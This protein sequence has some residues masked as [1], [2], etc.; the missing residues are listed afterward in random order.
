MKS[1]ALPF[2]IMP[3]TIII[4]VGSSLIASAQPGANIKI[5]TTP[6]RGAV[7]MLEGQGGNIGVSSGPDGVLIVDDQYD[8][9][10]EKIQTAI[11]AIGKGD[12]KFVLNTHWHG[13]HT[14]GN[15]VFGLHAP[16]IAHE[17]V[18]KRL[19]EDGA[20]PA[21]KVAL[22][23]ITY[24]DGVS[25]H[26]NGE[27]IRVYHLPTGHTDGD[28]VVYFTESNVMHMGDLFFSG[29]FPYI[30]LGSGGDVAGY[31]RNIGTV[32][33]RL[34]ADVKIIPGHGPLSTVAELKAFQAMLHETTGLVRER[35][36]AGKSLTEAQAMGMPEKYE[37][38]GKGFIN[39]DR[40][41][42][43]VYTSFTKK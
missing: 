10:A 33:E 1:P 25:V 12:V 22:P 34:P 30:D 11:A 13:D 26:F 18:R 38:W 28:S 2:A 31:V 4:V 39:T 40:W 36:A 9:L 6:V 21:P 29:R 5:I 27:T 20:T 42:E 7:Y 24:A 37:S 43:I 41:I 19:L 23:V 16:I 32:L 15:E 3:L 17:N 14:G 8:Y 35:I